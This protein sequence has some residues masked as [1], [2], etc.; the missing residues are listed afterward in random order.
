MIWINGR[1]AVLLVQWR[2][3]LQREPTMTFGERFYLALV[4]GTFAVFIIGMG[5]VSYQ[6]TCADRARARQ[7]DGRSPAE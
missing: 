7:G 6:Q 4:L 5:R 1:T 2:H 3:M